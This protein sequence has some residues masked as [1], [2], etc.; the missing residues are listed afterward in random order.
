MIS[1]IIYLSARSVDDMEIVVAYDIETSD[2]EGERRLRKVAKLCE[3]YGQRVQKS[4]F[5]CMLD[6]VRLRELI[7]DLQ[8]VI[9]PTC[10]RVSIYRLREPYG[11]YVRRLG[12]P[13]DMDP[14]SP[15]VL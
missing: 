9:E 5:E 1:I 11:A 12:R 7:H 2:R 10:D 15:F 14:R 6:A 13:G 8:L 3:G 4:V